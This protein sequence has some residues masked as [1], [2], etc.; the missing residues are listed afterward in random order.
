VDGIPIEVPIRSSPDAS[1]DRGS[2]TDLRIEGQSQA[3]GPVRF[4]F[5]HF[6]Q[7]RRQFEDLATN[8]LRLA[9][10]NRGFQAGE[11]FMGAEATNRHR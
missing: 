5:D 11:S 9:L 4:P 1:S 3:I 7:L 6:P 8:K 2:W 10:S